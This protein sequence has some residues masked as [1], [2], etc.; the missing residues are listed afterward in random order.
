MSEEITPEAVTEKLKQ[1][2]LLDEPKEETKSALKETKKEEISE[3]KKEA[4]L[5]SST[6]A[7]SATLEDSS[8]MEQSDVEKEAMAK[9]W[10]PEGEKSAE[11]FLRAEPLYEEIK[12]RGKE[13]KALRS[14]MN[15]LMNHMGNLKRAGYEDRLNAIKAEREDAVARSDMESLEYLDEEMYKV[16][17]EMDQEPASDSN[18]HPAAEAFVERH[19]DILEDYSLEAQEVKTFINER[20]QQ[21]GSYNLDPEVHIETLERDLRSRF[22][23]KF[24]VKKKT[25]ES[26]VTV[27]S[28]SVPVTSKKKSKYTFSDLSRDQKAIY[29][30]LEKTGVME[31]NEYIKQLIEIGELK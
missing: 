4:V 20:D 1:Q 13:I 22:P 24:G 17:S 16:K 18:M 26:S 5:E 15:E 6:I 19:R 9:G 30:R 2:G 25:K 8:E 23:E 21:L 10:K 31:G 27:E 14:Q 7:E 3:E 11:E 29:K 12:Q 28:D